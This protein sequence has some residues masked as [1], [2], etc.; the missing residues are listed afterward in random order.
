MLASLKID[1]FVLRID[2]ASS[3]TLTVNLEIFHHTDARRTSDRRQ[4]WDRTCPEVCRTEPL[5]CGWNFP[6]GVASFL[7]LKFRLQLC[8]W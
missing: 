6:E 4:E 3:G 5:E 7:I 2:F 1:D 8:C